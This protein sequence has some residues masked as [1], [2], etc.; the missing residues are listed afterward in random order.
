[1]SDDKFIDVIEKNRKHRQYVQQGA[2]LKHP[3]F[4]FFDEK[5]RLSIIILPI[6]PHSTRSGK[7]KLFKAS[8]GYRLSVV[9]GDQVLVDTSMF[10][11]I[12]SLDTIPCKKLTMDIKIDVNRFMFHVAPF[13]TVCI[14]SEF[15]P[16][17]P[18]RTVTLETTSDNPDFSEE[19]RQNMIY[20]LTDMTANVIQTYSTWYHE[21][22]I[23]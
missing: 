13:K 19:D 14:T 8:V 7:I 17:V 12:R 16:V 18:T 10:N 9:M 3:W 15:D 22:P 4:G 6:V 21:H 1:M 11:Q 23:T 2:D 5:D 20:S